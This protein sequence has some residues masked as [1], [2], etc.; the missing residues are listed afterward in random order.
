[1][2]APFLLLRTGPGCW[3]VRRDGTPYPGL[4]AALAAVRSAWPDRSDLQ[5][6]AWKLLPRL[7]GKPRT[8]NNLKTERARSALN[9]LEDI[10]LSDPWLA[11]NTDSAVNVLWA[12]TDKPGL[13]ER[14]AELT[15]GGM[16]VACATYSDN[17]GGH[18]A[19]ILDTPV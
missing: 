16:K 1:M 17:G 10:I 18:A 15:R 4:P 7:P 2:S 11:M 6:L 12:E 5:A 8:S 13:R 3:D 19:I 14:L 9:P